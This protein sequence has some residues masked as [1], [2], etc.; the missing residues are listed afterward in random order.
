MRTESSDIVL[1]PLRITKIVAAGGG[2]SFLRL[3][4]LEVLNDD[5]ENPP[6]SPVCTSVYNYWG[7]PQGGFYPGTDDDPPF[8]QA[9]ADQYWWCRD[10]TGDKKESERTRP[11]WEYLNPQMFG[12]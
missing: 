4:Q 6:E 5:P 7:A 3:P 10:T 11:L 8:P 2:Y 1:P 9:Q 12:Q